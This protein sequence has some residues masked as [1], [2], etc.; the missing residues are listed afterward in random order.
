MCR[1]LHTAFRQ[2][3]VAGVC[4]LF[5]SALI[6]VAI[7]GFTTIER[8]SGFRVPFSK[9]ELFRCPFVTELNFMF[10]GVLKHIVVFRP[11][12]DINVRQALT[13]CEHDGIW[14]RSDGSVGFSLWPQYSSEYWRFQA[15]G[16]GGNGSYI[17][18]REILR[19]W[20]LAPFATYVIAHVLGWSGPRV[21]PA[22]SDSNVAICPPLANSYVVGIDFRGGNRDKSALH[23]HQRRLSNFV[24]GISSLQYKLSLVSS[25]NLF[26]PLAHGHI[27]I[28]NYGKESQP[29]RHQPYPVPS[30]SAVVF[31]L[32]LGFCAFWLM[33]ES[34]HFYFGLLLLLI[35]ACV[36]VY[37]LN[38]IFD[39]MEVNTEGRSSL[40]RVAQEPL[41]EVDKLASNVIHVP[42]VSNRAVTRLVGAVSQ[43][44]ERVQG[45]LISHFCAVGRIAT[46]RAV[47]RNSHLDFQDVST[48]SY[49][50][51]LLLSESSAKGDGLCGVESRRSRWDVLICEF[52]AIDE[53]SP[54]RLKVESWNWPKV[55]N[56]S[57]KIH[58]DGFIDRAS[59]KYCMA[60]LVQE[61]ISGGYSVNSDIGTL[62]SVIR[63]LRQFGDLSSQAALPSR[64]S[65]VDNDGQKSKPFQPN[66]MGFTAK[67]YIALGYAC[68][69]VFCALG[70]VSLFFLWGKIGM[71][72]AANV[73]VVLALGV[74]LS[75]GFVWVGQW[76][77]F[78]VSG[79]LP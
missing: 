29:F 71:Y 30:L 33:Q 18:E 26:S 77:L 19:K 7:V 54:L 31:G 22:K 6:V 20:L 40:P 51:E 53:Y 48:I 59:T 34:D 58:A 44:E 49:P 78:S 15:S 24:R 39:V 21:T 61:N 62:R 66:F 79:L 73:N 8:R 28:E 67:V 65:S 74:L 57:I 27:S 52:H 16:A 14:N 41:G 72:D 38:G 3:S 17:G 45:I 37:G 12:P 11:A 43:I 32:A 70:A 76:M 36:F 60:P 2:G 63:S 64:D 47:I 56:L 42:Q 10:S 35:S 4:L 13:H 23:I 5:S 69:C 46:S 75:A 50:P 55:S 9:V 1:K 25:G 68:G